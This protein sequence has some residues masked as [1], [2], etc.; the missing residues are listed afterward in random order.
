MVFVKLNKTCCNLVSFGSCFI[1]NSSRMGL[2]LFIDRPA[3]VC[4][5]VN[6]P[7]VWPHTPYKRCRSDPPGCSKAL[8]PK[9]SKADKKRV[10]SDN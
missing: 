2:C 10:F 3:L 4:I 8:K 7:R 9:K 6:F 1:V 5:C